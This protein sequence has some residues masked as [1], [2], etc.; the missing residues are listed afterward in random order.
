[1][2]KFYAFFISIFIFCLCTS[3]AR[4]QSINEPIVQY[5]KADTSSPFPFSDAVRVGN[6]LYLSG[7]IGSDS[8]GKAVVPGGIEAE[9]R[10]AL[11]NIK[12]TLERNGSSMDRIVKCTVMLADIKE[13]PAMNTV[14]RTYFAKNRFPARSAF[15][16]SGLALGAR[17]EIECIATIGIPKGS[18]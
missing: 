7:A 5:M 8:T 16:G 2:R 3:T 10:Q 9:T 1:M 17:V 14:Y 12:K 6:M 13:W 11:E 15:A 4:T 18:R